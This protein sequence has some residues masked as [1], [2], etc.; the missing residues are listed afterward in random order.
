MKLIN[1]FLES[2]V[3][4]KKSIEPQFIYTVET[5]SVC[6]DYA[7]K[8]IMPLY[9]KILNFPRYNRF[10]ILISIMTILVIMQTDL[11]KAAEILQQDK[12]AVTAKYGFDFQ[13]TGN[14]II[15]GIASCCP[16]NFDGNGNSVSLTI[17]YGLKV[18]ESV[19]FSIL[20]GFSKSSAELS[21]L[22]NTIINLDSTAINGT[23]SHNL[24]T[25]YSS[26]LLGLKYQQDIAGTFGLGGSFNIALPVQSSYSYSENIITPIDRGVF[27]DTGTRRR[28]ELEGDLANL[29]TAI[30]NLDLF[31][32]KEMPLDTDFNWVAFPKIGFSYIISGLDNNNKWKSI[33][34]FIGISISRNNVF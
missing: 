28:N 17:D 26:F 13:N 34:I 1:I 19:F 11:L 22:E 20:I 5:D 6:N 32:G 14:E 29:R 8:L 12:F 9:S 24:E 7:I 31:L 2:F 33:A 30:F 15:D 27:P 16:E 18:S 3:E 25:N 4:S 10:A 21:V 23:F